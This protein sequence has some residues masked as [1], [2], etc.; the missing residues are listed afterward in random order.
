MSL[1]KKAV[2]KTE[3]KPASRSKETAWTVGPNQEGEALGLA[4][5]ELTQIQRQVKTLETKATN[6]KGKLKR[7]TERLWLNS[8]ASNGVQPPT[9]MKLSNDAGESVTFVVQDRT[10]GYEIKPAV[11]EG[12]VDTLGQGG[13]AAIVFEQVTFGFSP[14]VLSGTTA[15]GE[16]VQDWLAD[17]LT[18]LVERA[19]KEGTLTSEQAE[20]LVTA[21]QKC[22]FR[23]GLLERLADVCGADVTRMETV[24]EVVG[25]GITRYVKV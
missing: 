1:F 15:S 20:G 3:S 18:K 21:E 9:P 2:A 17:K 19:V 25:S 14:H 7:Y 5:T 6:L 4:I 11:M 12:L 24:L 10:S 13:A 16:L 8:F 23:P 22:A